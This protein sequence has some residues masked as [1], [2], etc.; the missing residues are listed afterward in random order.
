MLR[1]AVFY[2]TFFSDFLSSFL[3][4]SRHFSSFLVI[5]GITS[6]EARFFS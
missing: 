6:D 1:Q 5:V 3:V 4:I 2:T